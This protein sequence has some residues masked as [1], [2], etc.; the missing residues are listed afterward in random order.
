MRDYGEPTDRLT[1]A[2]RS[3]DVD[4]FQ[5]IVSNKLSAFT[6]SFVPFNI[7][8]N[9]VIN[10]NTRY[11][12]YAAAYGSVKIFKY[13]LLNHYS[14]DNYTFPYAVFG[15]NVEIIKIVQQNNDTSD[16][17]NIMNQ[18][19]FQYGGYDV[20]SEDG[21]VPAIMKHRNDLFDW[22]L[23]QPANYNESDASFV[24]NFYLTFS[25]E[26]GNCHS[27]I[28]LIE[29]EGS[30]QYDLMIL[31]ASCLQAATNGFYKVTELLMNLMNSK[32]SSFTI[33]DSSSLINFGNVSIL[34]LYLAKLSQH[35]HE[36]ILI[37]SIKRN[38]K[39]IVEFYYDTLKEIVSSSSLSL[40]VLRESIYCQTNEIF[41]Y[42]FD[43]IQIQNPS[44]FKD[45]NYLNQLLTETCKFTNN[46]EV[47][48]ILTELIIANNSSS[49]KDCDFTTF[50]FESIL[51]NSRDICQYFIDEKVTIEYTKLSSSIRQT[52]KDINEDILLLIIESLSIENQEIFFENLP[53]SIEKKY[54]R[55]VDYLLNK[56]AFSDNALQLAV[57][58]NDLEIVKLVLKYHNQPS[59]I[60]KR[61]ING[62]ALTI[63]ATN[64]NSDIFKHLLKLKGIDPYLFGARNLN[65][66]NQTVKHLNIELFDL[67]LNFCGE[68]IFQQKWMINEVIQEFVDSDQEKND[69]KNNSAE[70]DRDKIEYIFGRL[71][72]LKCTDI[73]YHFHRHTILTYACMNNYH[74]LVDNILKHEEIDVN[75][76]ESLNGDTPLIIS[77]K[78]NNADIVKVLLKH[79]QTNINLQNFD[80][81]TALTIATKNRHRQLVN[82]IIEDKR[83]DPNESKLNE[84]LKE[85]FANDMKEIVIDLIKCTSKE[86]N[87][88]R[89][90]NQRILDIALTMNSRE[91]VI[92][93]IL[94]NPNFDSKKSDILNAF[95]E[96]YSNVSDRCKSP[97]KIMK[98]LYDYDSEH[99]H[100]IDFKKLLPNGKTFFTSLN[101][102]SQFNGEIVHFFLSHGV[103]PNKPDSN[104][105]FPLEAALNF[106][107]IESAIELIKSNKIDFKQKIKIKNSKSEKD[108]YTTYLHLAA[109]S[110]NYEAIE[111][112][113]NRNLIS[114][115]EV[116]DLGDTALIAACKKRRKKNVIILFEFE[117]CNDCQIDYLH[118]NKEEKD[119]IQIASIWSNKSK[120]EFNDKEEY[121][122]ILLDLLS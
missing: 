29:K 7:Y 114:I 18:K 30:A 13:L 70:D 78:Q 91:E 102:K 94:K 61:F 45:D 90:N 108:E 22:I 66:L 88:I 60:N 103:D 86:I 42:L 106:E 74:K 77:A 48:K 72:N 41:K 46:I 83:F 97:I 57:Q 5:S 4:T 6:N 65:P 122:E 37:F 3:D 2:L 69:S 107:S 17:L 113:L 10:G 44:F 12:S 96:A 67:I 95:I 38:Y 23:M 105:I 73:N 63:A 52:D 98:M 1:K 89:I 50:L 54:Q 75:L 11:I 53:K 121:L 110:V 39:N 16:S 99:D 51:N 32:R 14:F 62:T 109:Q 26:N 93:E 104:G 35:Q 9:Y 40:K 81:Q 111:S 118:Q 19:K 31:E 58:T 101:G 117:F 71:L 79:P 24:K 36:S 84:A 120:K 28:E 85:A 64:N 25:V 20:Y 47:V 21:I 92:C 27:I 82:L 55:L 43:Q 68:N 100:L 59:F 56:G 116:D 15:G 80:Q 8:E 87:T 76:Y 49:S 34:K 33:P 112:I 119:A 115:N